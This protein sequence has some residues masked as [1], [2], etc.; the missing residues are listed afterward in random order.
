M[1][2]CNGA[3][4]E[5]PNERELQQVRMKVHDIEVISALT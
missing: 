5:A 4:G 2:G 3:T 1:K